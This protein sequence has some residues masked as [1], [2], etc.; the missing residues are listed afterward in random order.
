L[1]KVSLKA[2]KRL[3]NTSNKGF[4]LERERERERDDLKPHIGLVSS[5]LSLE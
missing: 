1:E 2:S 5:L 3:L 4:N